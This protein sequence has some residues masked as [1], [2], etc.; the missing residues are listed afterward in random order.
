MNSLKNLKK[1]WENFADNDPYWAVLT[2]YDDDVGRFYE[3]GRRD[4]AQ[5]LGRIRDLGISYGDSN[6]LDFG[7]GIGRLTFPLCEH[8]DSAVG[9]DISSKMVDLASASE[10]CPANAKFLVLSSRE[11]DKLGT[12][13]MDFV[14]SLMVLQHVPKKHALSY[15][16]EFARVLK[17]DGILAFQTVT[18]RDRIE[19]PIPKYWADKPLT[20]DKPSWLKLCY[21]AASRSLR[22][23]TRRLYHAILSNE[24]K[25]RFM[26]LWRLLLGKELMQM[27]CIP[28]KKLEKALQKSGLDVVEKTIDQR[29]GSGFTSHLYI[30]RKR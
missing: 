7:S 11:I 20:W 14:I 3:S 27:N 5:I 26:Y 1:N 6:V 23:V 29:A 17:R 18:H 9:V 16:E 2:S 15:L 22:F 13:S 25:Y 28:C 24:V 21:R 8:F 10:R 19:T 4:V 30:A 12:G